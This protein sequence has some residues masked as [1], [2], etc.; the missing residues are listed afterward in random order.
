MLRTCSIGY[1]IKTLPV[2]NELVE[3]MAETQAQL[4][5]LVE[6]FAQSQPPSIDP[7]VTVVKAHN[8]LA[9]QPIN[10]GLVRQ[11]TVRQETTKDVQTE[12]S[13]QQPVDVIDD[14]DAIHDTDVPVM[15]DVSSGT[16][17]GENQPNAGLPAVIEAFLTNMNLPADDDGT[18]ADIKDIFIEEAYEVLDT[19]VPEFESWAADTSNLKALTEVR[20]GFHTLKGSGRMVG[21]NHS[22]ELAWHVENMLNRVLDHSIAPDRGM[23][24]L[25]SDV[26][27]HYPVIIKAFEQGDD[28]YPK[29]MSLWAATAHAYSKKHGEEFDYLAISDKQHHSDTKQEEADTGHQL[30]LIHI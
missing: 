2:S 11:G 14:A 27:N 18:D 5:I 15:A 17:N 16:I 29:Q 30:S 20:R 13:T 7:A 12:P 9:Q 24:Q 3:F 6:N 26:L 25:I 1:W 8:L 21:A 23:I 10:T 22:G 4:P 19:I 28:S